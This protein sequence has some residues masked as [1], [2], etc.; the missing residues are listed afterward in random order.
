MARTESKSIQVHPV[1]EQKQ[2]DLMQK[3]H[4]SLL[5]SQEIKNVDSHLERRGDSIYSVTE[6]EH[7]IKLVFSREIDLPNLDKIKCLEN[8]FFAIRDPILSL[9]PLVPLGFFGGLVLFGLTFLYGLGILIYLA[10]YFKYYAPKKKE[11]EGT[12]NT[13]I[14]QNSQR[15]KEILAEVARFS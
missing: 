10:Y 14:A 5:S 8:E 2:I 4:W 15:R 3:F 1:D 6:S 13:T 9:P 7:Y 11:I 12:Y